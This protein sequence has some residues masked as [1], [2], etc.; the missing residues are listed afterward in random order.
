MLA[1]APLPMCAG[2]AGWEVVVDAFSDKLTLWDGVGRSSC[3]AGLR[4]GTAPARPAVEGGGEWGIVPLLPYSPAR[5]AASSTEA[6]AAATAAASA[7][8][9]ALP[10]VLG[11]SEA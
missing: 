11:A 5:A 3:A 1:L 10:P 8:A 7:A 4:T 6:A 9:A 2:P